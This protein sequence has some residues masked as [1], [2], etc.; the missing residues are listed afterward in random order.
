MPPKDLLSQAYTPGAKD[1]FA[2]SEPIPW[3]DVIAGAFSNSG[4]ST[5]KFAGDMWNAISHP[6][7]TGGTMV[8][9]VNGA[10]TLAGVTDNPQDAKKARAVAKM[11]NDKYGTVEGFKRALMADPV[12]ILGDLSM[13]VTGGAMGVGRVAALTGGLAKIANKGARVPGLSTAVERVGRGAEIFQTGGK[14]IDPLWMMGKTAGGLAKGGGKALAGFAGVLSGTGSNVQRVAAE[15]G[16]KGGSYADDFKLGRSAEFDFTD[17]IPKLQL[18]V[19]NLR[20]NRSDSYLANKKNWGEVT[21]PLEWEPIT[22]S[23]KEIMEESGFKGLSGKAKRVGVLSSTDNI[24]KKIRSTINKWRKLDPKEFHTPLGMD[25]LKQK[26]SDLGEG[27]KPGSAEARLVGKARDTIKAQIEGQAPGYK[28]AMGD[29]AEASRLL[30]KMKTIVK[31]DS[32]GQTNIPGTLKAI[33][34]ILKKDSTLGYKRSLTDELQKAGGGNLDEI[35]AGAASRDVLP[36]GAFNQVKTGVS[37]AGAGAIT[38]LLAIPTAIASSPRLSTT[39]GYRGGQALGG[40]QKLATS[41][42]GKALTSTQARL[43]AQLAGRTEEELRMQ[44]LYY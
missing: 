35:I 1:L 40:A 22:I 42:L 38:P 31:T 43:P 7:E 41:K 25:Q 3:S 15:A 26:I 37:T 17:V 32:K 18:A 21:A 19:Q 13:A 12:S 16:R 5:A 24:A 29:Y 14:M 8:D 33:S 44:G 11:Y 6:I 39:L 9:I 27:L 10:L 28:D 4:S 20:K 30:D 34:S 23:L 2:S 36:Q